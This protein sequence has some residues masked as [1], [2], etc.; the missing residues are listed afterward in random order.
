MTTKNAKREVKREFRSLRMT[1]AEVEKIERLS[2]IAGS[3]GNFSRTMRWILA[4]F[5]EPADLAAQ[6]MRGAHNA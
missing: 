2:P 1:P 3:P 6:A 4:T 5:P